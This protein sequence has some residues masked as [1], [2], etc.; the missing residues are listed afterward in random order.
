MLPEKAVDIL[1]PLPLCFDKIVF[2]C[3]EVAFCEVIKT[4]PFQS[5]ILGRD[6]DFIFSACHVVLLEHFN[7]DGNF[8]VGDNHGSSGQVGKKI[9][10]GLLGFNLK[11]L[12]LQIFTL[13]GN[14]LNNRQTN[15][16]LQP[17]KTI[18]NEVKNRFFQFSKTTFGV[19][20]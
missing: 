6:A 2:D 7:R 4:F 16:T 5:T 13:A 8:F 12:R 19:L 3:I 20:F 10:C 17:E 1:P 11:S 18:F 9:D 15:R 14:F